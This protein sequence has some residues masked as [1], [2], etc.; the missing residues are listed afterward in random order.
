MILNE[1][2]VK[3]FAGILVMILTKRH[4]ALEG[5]N[6]NVKVI[7]RVPTA[8]EISTTFGQDFILFNSRKKATIYYIGR[9]MN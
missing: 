9:K 5:T 1:R 6:N 8:I 4:S 7:N 3:F 2:R